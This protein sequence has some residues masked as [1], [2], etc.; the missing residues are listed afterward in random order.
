MN[1]TGSIMG[2]GYS[3]DHTAEDYI[4]IDITCNIEEPQQK[5]RFGTVSNRLRGLKLVVLDPNLALCFR[6]SEPFKRLSFTQLVTLC[7]QTLTHSPTHSFI[8][9]HIHTLCYSLTHYLTR[10]L[11]SCLIYFFL[12]FLFSFLPFSIR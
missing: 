2:N 3:I 7:L 11:S 5:Y 10:S 12:S 8:H 1:K 4:H 9:S 6:S